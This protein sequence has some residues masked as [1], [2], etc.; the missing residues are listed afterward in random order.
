MRKKLT[1]EEICAVRRAARVRMREAQAISGLGKNALYELIHDG[2]L[3]SVKVGGTGLI[4]V[5]ALESLVG[6]KS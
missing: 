4:P 2:V 6:A 3:P 5:A 1:P